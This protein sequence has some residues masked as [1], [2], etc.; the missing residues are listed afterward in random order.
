[1]IKYTIEVVKEGLSIKLDSEIIHQFKVGE[2]F[3]IEYDLTKTI[4]TFSIN[5]RDFKINQPY[6]FIEL[7]DNF[8]ATSIASGFKKGYIIDVT[9]QVDRNNKLK[10]LGL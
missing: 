3:L 9:L 1:M 7:K 10:Q 8:S 2:L 5:G 6:F 4:L